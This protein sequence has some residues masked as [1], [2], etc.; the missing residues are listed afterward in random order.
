MLSGGARR[1]AALY[2]VKPGTTAVVATTGDR[3]LEAALALHAAGVR[4]AAV[5]DLR[6]DAGGG[7]RGRPGRG[8][9]HRADARRDR[10]ARPRPPGGDRRG[11]RA[12]RRARA[13]RSR[14]GERRV[15][16]DLIAVSG[17]T[18]PATSLLLQGGA[19]ARY[20]EATGRF[21][22]D[23]L[24]DIVL[25]AGSVAGHDDADTAELSGLVA[26]AEAALALGHGAAADSA[27][28]EQDR[29]RLQ[30]RPAPSPVATPPAVAR[31]H[32]K[33]GKA[34]IDLDE[35]VTT[36]DIALAAARGLRLDRALQA[37]HDRDDGP[38]PGPLLA[39][40]LDPR[41][42]RSTPGSTLE[43]VGMTTARPPWVER[44][45]GRARGPAVRAGQAL[46]DPRPAARAA[47][48]GEV[49]GRL[50]ARLRLRRPGGR[51]RRGPRARGRDRRLDARQAARARAG[52]GRDPR[53]AVPEPVLEPQAGARPLRR[54]DLRGRADH[55][56]RH[57]LPARRRLVLRDDDVERRRRDRGVVRLVA[58]DVG[59]RRQGHRRHAGAVRGQRRRAR[60]RARSWRG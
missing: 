43:A 44:A 33:G 20:D 4:I 17:G 53:P 31:D 45:D 29:A 6:P 1:L 24:H 42:R 40:R 60:R 50:A 55:G 39:A 13:T 19:R 14:A 9:R 23:G 59:H 47:R 54:D 3:G 5:A 35:D 26:G 51:G 25:A 57:D 58:G 18:A 41:A 16:C 52:R 12:R 48:H 37:L 28:L 7:E 56:R 2:G 8:G 10:R 49:G 15:A 46:G 22:A 34:F 30:D 27:T 38:L 36:K 21:V 32:E 11:A